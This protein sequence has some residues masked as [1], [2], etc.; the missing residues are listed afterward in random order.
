MHSL[1][2]TIVLAAAGVC[3]LAQDERHPLTSGTLRELLVSAP[4]GTRVETFRLDLEG[5]ESD[6]EPAGVALLLVEPKGDELRLELQARFFDAATQVVHV[7][8]IGQRARELV[9]REVRSAGGRTLRLEWKEG[10]PATSREV[11]GEE[12]ASRSFAGEPDFFLPLALVE[13]ARSGL[14]REGPVRVYAP[15]ASG[16]EE[17]VLRMR[18]EASEP[19]LPRSSLE[20]ERGGRLA[21]RF[22]FEAGALQSFRWQAGGLVARAV[23]RADYDRF[24][25]R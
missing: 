24:A 8:S 3:A 9:F 5:A 23:T 16:V 21:G 6:A 15:L 2:R 11:V 17:L 13:L 1:L 12:I 22:T 10:S 4:H 7:E 18:V 14:V 25:L 19:D 20:L